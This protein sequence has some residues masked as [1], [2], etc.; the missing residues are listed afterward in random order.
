[1]IFKVEWKGR[2][3]KQLKMVQQLTIYNE[4]NQIALIAYWAKAEVYQ[5]FEDVTLKPRAPGCI[6][7]RD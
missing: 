7:I 5:G 2:V 1:M 6:T 4:I 3:S